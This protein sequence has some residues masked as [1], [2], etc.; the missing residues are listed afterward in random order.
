MAGSP[1][2]PLNDGDI[3]ARATPFMGM[4][5]LADQGRLECCDVTGAHWVDVDTRGDLR[6]A[7]RWLLAG[8]GKERDGA[9]AKVNRVMSGRVITPRCYRSRQVASDTVTVSPPS[10]R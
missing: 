4:H 2:Q 9:V 7:S 8:G 3:Y 1:V 5:R 10:L 6:M